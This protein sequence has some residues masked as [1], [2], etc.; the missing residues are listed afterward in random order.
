MQNLLQARA[1]TRTHAIGL[2][3]T[4]VAIHKDV[5]KATHRLDV[6]AIPLKNAN[7]I[8]STTFTQPVD[9]ETNINHTGIRHGTEEVTARVDSEPDYVP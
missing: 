5:R 3:P 7:F 6:R 1:Y 2:G 4:A 8:S 9:T